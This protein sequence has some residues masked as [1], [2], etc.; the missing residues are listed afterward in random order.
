MMSILNEFK[1]KM[2]ELL[3]N[4][5][6]LTLTPDNMREIMD[7]LNN[8]TFKH[9]IHFEILKTICTMLKYH[10]PY[11]FIQLLIK[12][13]VLNNVRI[14]FGQLTIDDEEISSIVRLN[15]SLTVYIGT[16]LDSMLEEMKKENPD[17]KE[18]DRMAYLIIQN[19]NRMLR[20]T[21]Q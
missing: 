13:M 10:Y 15:F 12:D 14:N 20:E 18:I 6:N 1:N 7:E 19:I 5:L 16:I 3:E 8:I 9:M 11:Q 17:N 2:N 4:N 21:K